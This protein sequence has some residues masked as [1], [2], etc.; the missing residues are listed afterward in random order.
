M[1]EV[2]VVVLTYNRRAEAARTVERLLGLPERPPVI[3]VDNASTDGTAG[4]L[5]ACYP[6]IRVLQEPCNR[7]AAGRNSGALAAATPYVAFCDDDTWWEPGALREAAAVLDRHPGI[8]SL[9]A[10]V[11]VGEDEAE[12]PTCALMAR[13]PLPR[14]GLPGPALLGLLAGATVFRREAF[15]QVGGYQPRFFLGGEESLLALDLA[16][17]GWKL[18]YL[19]SLR[20]HHHP[21]P[22]RDSSAR[23]RLLA[24]NALWTAWMRR[25][26]PVAWRQTRRLLAEARRQGMLAAT[27][28]SALAGL[29]WALLHRRANPAAVE[30]MCL[31]LEAQQRG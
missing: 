7:G 22:L 18:V 28:L 2:S 3:V 15:L 1:T 31:A 14:D 4:Y 23:R 9:T 30:R 5:R 24:R 21:S 10:R 8:A 12:D 16:A 20:V 11:L 13:S 19:P 6:G 27:G 29:P 26:W 25:P 17:A